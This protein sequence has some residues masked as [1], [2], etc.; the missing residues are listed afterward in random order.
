[1]YFCFYFLFP[2][3]LRMPGGLEI[4]VTDITLPPSDYKDV[5]I[6]ILKIPDSR[7]PPSAFVDHFS[8]LLA[9]SPT[10]VMTLHFASRFLRR[11]CASGS[12]NHLPSLTFLHSLIVR[13]CQGTYPCHGVSSPVSPHPAT[14]LPVLPF[15][16]C[17]TE[18]VVKPPT[19]AA[20]TAP[21]V[22]T[23]SQCP[24]FWRSCQNW[25]ELP[26][27][28]HPGVATPPIWTV[29]KENGREGHRAVTDS[30]SQEFP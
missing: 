14:K 23:R 30:D 16:W 26:S 27:S 6:S 28:E 29:A 8:P 10:S 24:P 19:H 15:D 5:N 20:P 11:Y 17:R 21:P 25:H 9:F 4:T 13:R 18:P 7:F 1:L 12:S 3:P 2:G 22:G